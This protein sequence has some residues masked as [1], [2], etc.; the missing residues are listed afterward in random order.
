MRLTRKLPWTAALVAALACSGCTDDE[1]RR[2][3]DELLD[4]RETERWRFD[5]LT[6]PVYVL[7]TEANVPHIYGYN[8][9][10]VGFTLGFVTARDRY[11][12]MD[13]ERRLGSGTLAEVLGDATLD[14]DLESRGTGMTYAAQQ[15]H[16]GL[17]P[18]MEAYFDAYAAG[19]NDPGG[20]EPARSHEALR[21]LQR[22]SDGR[23][24]DVRRQLRRWR[25]GPSAD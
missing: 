11:F 7:R 9:R 20:V 1:E 4:V 15:I 22:R 3:L 2:P 17:T 18:E 19:V 21:S 24:R 12:M 10:D 14:I 23:R 16:D 25:R 13:L 8:Q 5:G 6:A